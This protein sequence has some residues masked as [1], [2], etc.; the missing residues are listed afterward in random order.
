LLSAALP[1]AA[2]MSMTRR[3]SFASSPQT[4]A[5]IAAAG[6]LLGQAALHLTCQAHDQRSHLW[7]F[8]TGALVV[9]IMAGLA[10]GRLQNG[11]KSAP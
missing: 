2:L 10:A 3:A 8:H 7:V 4:A 5:A 11:K 6:A 1:L 9:A